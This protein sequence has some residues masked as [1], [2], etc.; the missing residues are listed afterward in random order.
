MP[1]TENSLEIGVGTGRFAEALK[2]RYGVDPAPKMLEL[3]R[4]RGI[5][6]VL[7]YAEK[8]PFH[9]DTFD[10]VFMITTLCFV[11]DQAS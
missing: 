8:L 9:N 5:D 1:A 7:G 6:T 10:S 4:P 3:A 11:Q 2:I